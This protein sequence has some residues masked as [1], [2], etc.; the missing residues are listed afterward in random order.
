MFIKRIAERNTGEA[1]LSLV[2]Q[3]HFPQNYE[4][5]F[6]FKGSLQFKKICLSIQMEEYSILYKNNLTGSLKPEEMKHIIK[7]INNQNLIHYTNINKTSLKATI[8]TILPGWIYH[9]VNHFVTLS[10][11][12]KSI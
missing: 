2:H 6:Q 3:D 8:E 11:I 12:L 5:R 1:K 4:N 7:L 9:L 10:G